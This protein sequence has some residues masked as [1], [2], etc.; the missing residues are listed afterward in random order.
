MIIDERTYTLVPNKVPEFLALYQREGYP[1]Q[2]RHLGE[3][4]GF[5]TTDIGTLNQIIHLWGY[6]DYADRQARRAGM[7]ADPE[8][9]AY[10][11]KASQYFLKMENRIL[12]PTAF[13]KIQ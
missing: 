5:F 10:L 3:P 12:V 1:V 13:S 8:W 11:A 6:K 2:T 7:V 9:Q 4:V